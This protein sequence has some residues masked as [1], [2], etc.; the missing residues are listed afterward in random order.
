MKGGYATGRG[1]SRGGLGRDGIERERLS[2]L[3]QVGSRK[4][5]AKWG[6]G[7]GVSDSIAKEVVYLGAMRRRALGEQRNYRIPGLR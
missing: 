5:G 1:K 4:L 2:G 7:G 6:I 3:S